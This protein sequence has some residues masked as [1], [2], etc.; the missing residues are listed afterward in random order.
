[1]R[2]LTDFVKCN[3]VVTEPTMRAASVE[4]GG[5]ELLVPFFKAAL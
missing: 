1:M 4:E 5:T 3:V 2:E